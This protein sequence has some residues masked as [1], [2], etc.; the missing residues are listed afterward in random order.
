MSGAPSSVR[1]TNGQHITGS[2]DEVNEQRI[3]EACS[4]LA[5]VL[6][7]GLRTEHGG[8]FGIRVGVTRKK[9]GVIREVIEKT[10]Q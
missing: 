9:I 10:R 2:L 6:R 3:K 4:V 1:S 8:T 7:E 5:D